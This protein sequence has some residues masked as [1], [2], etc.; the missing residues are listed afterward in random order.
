M[1]GGHRAAAAHVVIV[2]L[3]DS[4]YDASD[5]KED[6]NAGPPL[7]ARRASGYHDKTPPEMA[8]TT[9]VG[10][11]GRPNSLPSAWPGPGGRRQYRRSQVQGTHRA[12]DERLRDPAGRA[13]CQ[14]P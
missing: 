1:K 13:L 5:D 11:Y 6:T 14:S 3:K 2:G 12:V 9:A 8:L 10:N 4:R 7:P